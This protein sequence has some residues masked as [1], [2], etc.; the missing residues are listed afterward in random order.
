MLDFLPEVVQGVVNDRNAGLT[1]QAIADKHG[2]PL[3]HVH[4]ICRDNGHKLDDISDSEID[5]DKNLVLL[6]VERSV[7]LDRR[8]GLTFSAIAEKR[9]MKKN[10]VT[11]I[12]EK[13]KHLLVGVPKYARKP[14]PKSIEELP[15]REQK[16]LNIRKTGLTFR[17]IAEK[18]KIDQ[19]QIESVCS[20]YRCFVGFGA[21]SPKR[22]RSKDRLRDM[23]NLRRSGM[24]LINI[25]KKFK[26]SAARVGQ[27]IQQYV[28][29][30]GEIE[31]SFVRSSK[32]LKTD[33]PKRAYEM[34]LKLM[35]YREIRKILNCNDSTARYFVETY[36]K[37]NNLT[38][39]HAKP[40]PECKSINELP[41]R[42]KSIL[43]AR[44]AGTTVESVAEKHKVSL[45]TVARVCKTY[46]HLAG[47]VTRKYTKKQ[48]TQKKHNTQKTPR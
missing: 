9:K 11:Q 14:F 38:I 15:K 5:I 48:I 31:T 29:Q 20:K 46:G 41:E 33:K 8:A 32:W 25:G 39:P 47:L 21:A 24:T 4:R 10:I 19:K 1:L 34:R 40:A 13:Y 17:E 2:L 44:K 23:I 42:T 26:L 18:L 27:L 28:D 6:Y 30:S 36:C 22:L 43:L 16:I 7:L 35:P 12:C 45:M 3:Q 37:H